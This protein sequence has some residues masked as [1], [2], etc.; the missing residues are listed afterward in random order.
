MGRRH[1]LKG[2]VIGLA[3]V[4]HRMLA[5]KVWSL[6]AKGRHEL[7]GQARNHMWSVFR[8]M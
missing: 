2:K 7:S 4:R 5:Q 6:E 3:A 1:G 8:N